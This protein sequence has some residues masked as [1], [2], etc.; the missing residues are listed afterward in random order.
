MKRL[1]IRKD[2]DDGK[3]II[4]RKEHKD[5]YAIVR[6]LNYSYDVVLKI[7]KNYNFTLDR[8]NAILKIMELDYEL[9]ESTDW[10]KVEEGAEVVFKSNSVAFEDM[11]YKTNCNFYSYIPNL[12]MVVLIVGNEVKVVDEDKVELV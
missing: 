4:T 9:Y 11:V 3:I 7:G 10:N 12:N 2:Y 5:D 1:D 6:M 8:A